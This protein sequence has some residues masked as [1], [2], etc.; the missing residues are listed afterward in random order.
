VIHVAVALFVIGVLALDF[1]ADMWGRE[2]LTP[3]SMLGWDLS[4][5]IV[6]VFAFWWFGLHWGCGS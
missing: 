4:A 2:R 3:E 5:L 1:C 6:G